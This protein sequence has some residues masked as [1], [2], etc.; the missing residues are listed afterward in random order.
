MNSVA[1]AKKKASSMPSAAVPK[2][3]LR[4]SSSNEFPRQG[5][6]SLLPVQFIETQNRKGTV[7]WNLGCAPMGFLVADASSGSWGTW[8]IQPVHE[9]VHEKVGE[10]ESFHLILESSHTSAFHLAIT[11][12]GDL[13]HKGGKGKFAQWT[14]SK[15]GK[16]WSL[17]NVGTELFI[18]VSNSG[19]LKTSLEAKSKE[20]R[21]Q[22][23]TQV[24]PS[25]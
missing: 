4:A 13:T 17:Q 22:I 24:S 10:K 20:T 18:A 14:A 12:A 3:I 23:S 25:E 9:K 5:P 16:F 21:F 7:G 1:E 2:Q 8:I 11:K 6:I 19:V 15:N